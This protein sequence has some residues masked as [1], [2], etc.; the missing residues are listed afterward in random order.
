[1]AD[2]LTVN[3]LVTTIWLNTNA[4]GDEGALA[5]ADVIKVNTSVTT[6]W[7]H[8][9]AIGD[10]GAS[11]LA[12]ALKVNTSVTSLYLDLD[13]DTI[14]AKRLASIHELID[15]NARLRRLFLFD[16]RRMLLS[17]MC[18][19]ECGVVWPYLLKRG[20]TDGTV[21]PDNVKRCVPSSLLS[22]RS[23]AAACKLCQRRNGVVFNDTHDCYIVIINRQS[24]HCTVLYSICNS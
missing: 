15:R 21:V 5:F 24:E 7:L 8:N 16:A 11:A 4:I 3:T 22:L 6:I 19:D 2:A 14:A 10:A 9:N 17:L 13:G 12:D 23:V 20:D 18:A 1:L